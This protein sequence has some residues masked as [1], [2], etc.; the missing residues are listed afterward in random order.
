VQ[1]LD[2]VARHRDARFAHSV[3]DDCPAPVYLEAGGACR[4]PV[5]HRVVGRQGGAHDSAA[6]E[7]GDFGAA[8]FRAAPIADALDALAAVCLVGRS[9]AA[10]SLTYCEDICCDVLSH[11]LISDSLRKVLGIGL[12]EA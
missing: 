12:V 3:A 2:A 9:A 6:L 4:L 10:V 5:G 8:C 11:R 7:E 1:P